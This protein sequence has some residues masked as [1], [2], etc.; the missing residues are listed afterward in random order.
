MK[1]PLKWNDYGLDFSKPI[2]MG[3]LNITPDSFSDGGKYID[4]QMA[5]E[6][7]LKMIQDGA[8]II[9]IG[10]ESSR[11]GSDPVTEQ[12]ELKRVIPVITAIRERTDQ[13]ISIDTCK[14]NVARQALAAGANWVNDISGVRH[15]PNMVQILKEWNCPVIVMH[16][17]GSPKTMQENPTYTDVIA[18]VG[19]FFTERIQYLRKNEIEKLVLDPGIG[20]GKRLED[21]LTILGHIKRLSEHG[22]PLLIGTSRKSFI[23]HLTGKPDDQ[24]E[25]GTLASQVWSIINGVHIIRTHEVSQTQEALTIVNSILQNVN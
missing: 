23:G 19:E 8:D 25:A 14:A 18:E 15:D 7:A 6:H 12:E 11:P 13:L 10:G 24:R 5:F 2:I 9:D 21:N 22:Y 3:I 20:F 4:P 16:M 17:K 1:T